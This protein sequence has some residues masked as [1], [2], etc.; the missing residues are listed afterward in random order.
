MSVRDRVAKTVERA[1]DDDG[2]GATGVGLTL[3]AAAIAAVLVLPLLW[4]V[5]DAAGLGTRAFELAVDSQT[6]DVLIRSVA[7]VTIVTGASVL[8]GVPLAVLTVQG[9]IPFPRFWTVLIALPLAVPSYLGAFAFVSAF[10]PQ[11][12]LVGFLEPLGV[13]ALPSVYGFTGAAF[14]LTLYTYPYVFLTTRASLLSMDGS[15]VEAAR[16]LNSGRWEAFRRITLPQILPG[17][18]AGALLVALYALADFGTP[19]IMR[20]EVFTQFIYARYNAFARDYAAL[21]SLQ[22]LTVTV[23]ILAIESRIG[24]DDSGAYESGGDRGTADLELGAWRY[25]AL[26]LP[27]AIALLAIGL[28]IAIFTMWLNT[29]GPG[30]QLGRLTFDWEYGFNSAYVALLA[31]LVSVLVA[32]PIAIG[33]ATSDS[34]VA[35]LADRAPYIGYATPGIVLAIAL[36]SFSLDVLPSI[37]KTVPLLVFAYVVRFMPQAIG[38]IR[39]STLQVDQKLVEAARTL[40][41]SRLNAFR[42]VTLPLILPGVA[43]GAALVFLTTMKELPATLMLR[44]LGFE[45]LVTYIWRVEEAG[46]YGQAAVP[47]LVLVAISGLSMAVMLAQE[48]R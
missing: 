20:V 10:G 45:T 42:S 2:S 22:L 25:P 13:D 8:I 23:I 3:L 18:A 1:G 30:Y 12:E 9:E 41:R 27:I 47:A 29:G 37:Y 43:A 46:L 32:L 35:A 31:A 24:A 5:V 40:G 38:S 39:T 21:L 16:T 19:N 4:L 44:P 6:I 11:G 26:L 14:V 36:L 34:R 28:P 48:G 17:I 7:L 33:S 15:L